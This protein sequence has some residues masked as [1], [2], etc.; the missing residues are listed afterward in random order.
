MNPVAPSTI[1]VVATA[2][3]S[4]RP[5]S[6]KARA[7]ILAAAA[8]LIAE[9][10]LRGIS[11]DAVAEQA[12]VSK[13]TIYRWWPSK[14]SLALEIF[15]DEVVKSQRPLPDRGSLRADLLA[16]VSAVVR[17]YG[18]AGTGRV[19]AD[20][21]A[22]LPSD[23]QLA[24]SLRD[25]VIEPVR[26]GNRLI[27]ER[28]VDRREMSRDTDTDVA[29]DMLYGAIWVRLLVRRDTLDQRFARKLVEV[30][31]TGLQSRQS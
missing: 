27:F 23:R 14:G 30:A 26:A 19:I 15:L 16:H 24:T 7:A 9:R 29:M 13:A 4:G 17:S 12:G 28:A 2:R 10:G 5:R 3:R 1:P 21:I 22:E 31:L 18:K 8:G 20:L 11:M 6:Q 25:K